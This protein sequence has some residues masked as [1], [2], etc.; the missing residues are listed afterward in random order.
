M[1]PTG[2]FF[3]ELLIRSAPGRTNLD[4]VQ[5]LYSGSI[6]NLWVE[7]LDRPV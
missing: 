7:E 6:Y 1:Q 2:C 4:V 5:T 3:D